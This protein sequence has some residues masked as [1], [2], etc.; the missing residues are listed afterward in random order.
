MD[1]S[2]KCRL[3]DRNVE[4]PFET[5]IRIRCRS[6]WVWARVEISS[7][8]ETVNLSGLTNGRARQLAK[9]LRQHVV[10]ALLMMFEPHG[11][12]LSLLWQSYEDFSKNTSLF[13]AFGPRDLETQPFSYEP[14]VGT[15]SGGPAGSPIL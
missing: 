12:G 6:G 7:T 10:D 13:V 1:R 3:P 5:I 2:F 11:E 8:R 4:F 9:V 14:A 15:R